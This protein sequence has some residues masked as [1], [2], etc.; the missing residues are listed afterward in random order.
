M[1]DETKP[2]D[3]QLLVS[4][5]KEI[6]EQSGL[7]PKELL[8]Q[9]KQDFTEAKAQGEAEPPQQLQKYS[10]LFK[11]Y[12]T[13]FL[14][15]LQLAREM[16]QQ[17]G[18][19]YTPF[20]ENWEGRFFY[21]AAHRDAPLKTHFS[22]IDIPPLLVRELQLQNSRGVGEVYKWALAFRQDL[23]ERAEKEAGKYYN[24]YKMIDIFP[25]KFVVKYRNSYNEDWKIAAE[26][27]IPEKI[28][29]ILEIPKFKLVLKNAGKRKNQVIRF[30]SEV[31][32]KDQEQCQ[33]LVENLPIVLQEGLSREDAFAL[34]EKLENL[35]AVV[36]VKRSS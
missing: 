19:D 18:D 2:P 8:E 3:D 12:M 31:L 20:V 30:V 32:G 21:G 14:Q 10:M 11:E 28:R 16:V 26:F 29:E 24:K 35:G 7:Q 17:L 27:E 33:Q 6:A 22:E 25:D 4:L 5:I 13:F 9:I 15:F 1:A 34:R 23:L 36:E